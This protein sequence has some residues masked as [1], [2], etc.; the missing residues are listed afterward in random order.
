M[1]WAHI[2]SP[3]AS[4]AAL[5]DFLDAVPYNKIS[6]FGGDYI[7]ADGIY[8]H[9][10]LSFQNVSEALAGKVER[11]VFTE[12]KAIDIAKALY[13]YNPKRIFKLG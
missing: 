3:S 8:G 12:E 5:S 4:V 6:A 10:E 13:Y 2:I 1:C 11:G 7:F 9:L